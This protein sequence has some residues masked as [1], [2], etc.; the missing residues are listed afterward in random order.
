MQFRRGK[1]NARNKKAE[2]Y[3]HVHNIVYNSFQNNV[4]AQFYFNSF[5]HIRLVS[6]FS[7]FVQRIGPS[8]GSNHL[9]LFYG[10]FRFVTFVHFIA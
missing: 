6:R 7:I 10:L 2:E 9:L 5:G 1:E 3:F 8:N 4:N